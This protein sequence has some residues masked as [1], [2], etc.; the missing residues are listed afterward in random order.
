MPT[1]SIYISNEDYDKFRAIEKKSEFIHNALN[2][3]EGYSIQD[4]KDKKPQ[5]DIKALSGISDTSVGPIKTKEDAINSTSSGANNLAVSLEPHLLKRK[6]KFESNI[7]S[8]PELC[9]HGAD[10]KLCKFAKPGKPCK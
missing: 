7:V 6:T 4:F 1:V 10:P 8:N 2:Q 9:K 3:D 5:A